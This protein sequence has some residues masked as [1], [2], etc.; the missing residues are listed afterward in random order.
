[1]HTETV[2]TLDD[3]AGHGARGLTVKSSSSTWMCWIVDEF[4]ASP[5]RLWI[6]YHLATEESKLHC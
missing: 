1:M 6:I 3:L 5:V 4:Q 2:R